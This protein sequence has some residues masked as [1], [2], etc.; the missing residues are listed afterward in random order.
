[1]ANDLRILTPKAPV[2]D[3]HT[4]TEPQKRSRI[5]SQHSS[6]S[7]RRERHHR[8]STQLKTLKPTLD[9]FDAFVQLILPHGPI[10]HSFERVWWPGFCRISLVGW[11]I[12]CCRNNCIVSRTKEKQID[13]PVVSQIPCRLF[14]GRNTRAQYCSRCGKQARKGAYHRRC[15]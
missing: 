2:P 1:M 13:G 10:V 9:P 3:T 11:D 6:A 7:A 8:N 12:W 4:P 5:F 15:R 14:F